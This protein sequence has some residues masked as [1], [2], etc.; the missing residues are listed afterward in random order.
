MILPRERRKLR[1]GEGKN[2]MEEGEGDQTE[3]DGR[4]IMEQRRISRGEREGN[5]VSTHY[6]SHVRIRG[7]RK[8]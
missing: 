2:R 3:K 8:A 5:D 7:R 1:G 6:L 4:I